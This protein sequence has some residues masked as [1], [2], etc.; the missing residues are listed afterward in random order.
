MIAATTAAVATTNA[1]RR[2]P[3][4]IDAPPTMMIARS[5]VQASQLKKAEA[6]AEMFDARLTTSAVA[7]NL[8]SPAGSYQCIN[9]IA[10][11]PASAPDT[12][13]QKPGRVRYG[14]MAGQ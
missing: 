3:K 13:G 12:N 2:R 6:S 14:T 1:S 5:S 4:M 10:A 9:V 7:V 8:P 11:T